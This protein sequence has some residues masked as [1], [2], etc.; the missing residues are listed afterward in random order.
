[1]LQTFF[2]HRTLKGKYGSPRALEGHLGTQ[3]LEWALGHSKNWGTKALENLR[4][5]GT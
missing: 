3:A 4:P 5:L 2:T 1:M